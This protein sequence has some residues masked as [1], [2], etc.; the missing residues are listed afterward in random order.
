M[1]HSGNLAIYMVK[2]NLEIKNEKDNIGHNR[3]EENVAADVSALIAATE[4][5]TVELSL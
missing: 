4:A 5:L 2:K 1:L 3:K